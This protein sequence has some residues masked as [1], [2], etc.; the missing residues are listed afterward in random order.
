MSLY[1]VLGAKQFTRPMLD[2]IFEVTEEMERIVA[3]GGS[4]TYRN[5]VMTTLFFEPSTR[6]RLSFESAMSRLGGKV[7][8]TENAAQFSSTIKGETLEDTI[9]V[10]SA[11][12]DVIVIR[13]TDI[14]AAERAAAVA[15]VPVLN[16][17]DGAGEHPTQSL[18]DL[19]TIK[20]EIGRLDDLHIVMI[21]D[22]ANGR[23]VHSLS[24]MLT[25]YKNIRISFTAP[26][27]VQIPNYVKKYL[28]EKGVAY[29]EEYDLEK[30]ARTA[31]VLYQTRI[32]K[33]RFTS[34]SEYKKACGQ[35]IIDSELLK[36]MKQDSIILHPLPRAGEIAV[37][38]DEDPRA[39]Y[40]RQ[41]Q[42][43]L[44]VRMALLD[45]AFRAK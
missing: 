15:T 37:E 33:E 14:G 25:N 38:V 21:G 39:A 42:N 9:K 29:E 13:H 8:G 23:T 1:H 5:K 19:Y 34:L 40:F 36:V 45:Q 43:G 11:Y 24:Y 44:F 28:D 30:V 3:D 27:N 20:K 7:I 6:T 22:L 26:E 10:V 2:Q 35:Y 18:L 16:A 4:D 17:G 41:A 32:Q 12:S 31:D